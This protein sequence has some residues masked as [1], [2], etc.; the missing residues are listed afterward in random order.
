MDKISNSNHPLAPLAEKL[1]EYAKSNDVDV[2]LS[3]KKEMDKIYGSIDG[4]AA[5]Y[6]GSF[7]NIII[8]KDASFRGLGVEPTLLHEILHSLTS[9]ELQNN[10]TVNQ[11]FLEFYEYVKEKLPNE[12]A[13]KNE[14]EFLVGL[15]TDAPFIK[16]MQEIAPM[17]TDSEYKNLFE[18][19][20]DYILSLFNFNKNTTA[21]D[22]AFSVATNVIQQAH[23][24][25][26]ESEG[27]LQELQQDLFNYPLFNIESNLFKNDNFKND[28]LE[29][30]I[31]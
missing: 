2:K 4:Y 8:D 31:C 29:D 5:L 17:K 30:N 25:R 7:N 27:K 12:Y 22:Q 28:T 26:V 14:D 9:R 24:G 20:F 15:F 19:L 11:N 23:D 3:N 18:E 6:D 1:K 16:K 10:T 21:Y 13:T